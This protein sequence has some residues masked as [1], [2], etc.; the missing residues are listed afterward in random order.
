MRLAKIKNKYLFKGDKPEGT[1]TYAVYYDKPSKRYRAVA[2][3]HLYVK[4]DKRFKQVKK[5]NIRIE[6]F[7]EFD[8][9]SGVQNYYYDTTTT[10]RKIDLSDK[11][12]VIKTEKR[13]L[14]KKQSERIKKFATK[15]Y[16]NKK[17]SRR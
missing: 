14:S 6:K 16:S 12:N 2:L 3:T 7:K 5:G 1:H 11:S 15:K 4:D 13:Y 10:G 9:P 17:N 8:V